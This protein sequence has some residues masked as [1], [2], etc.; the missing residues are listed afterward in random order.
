MYA[1]IIIDIAHES[2]DR[3][4]QYIV[5]PQ[6][7]GKLKEGM[8]VLVPFGAGNKEKKGYIVGFSEKCNYDANKMKE[9]YD[10]SDKAV[11]IEGRLVALAGWIKENYGGTM[12]QS[13]ENRSSG[14]TEKPGK[15]QQDNPTSFNGGRG[16]T[17]V[18]RVFA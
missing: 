8:E 7:E 9:I 3:V 11:Q 17:K 13:V 6:L 15:N 18:G 2:V 4:F 16:K 1:D 14:Q 10:I 12:I 5:P